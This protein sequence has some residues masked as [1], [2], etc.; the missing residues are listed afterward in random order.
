MNAVRVPPAC[1]VGYGVPRAGVPAPSSFDRWVR[2]A[3]AHSA[4]R[5]AIPGAY[6]CAIRLV[7]AREG[8]QLNHFWRG[9]DHATN[10]LSFPSQVPG[11]STPAQFW[12]GD[13]VLCAPVIARESRAQSRPPRDHYA[14]L[15]VH[16]VLHLL[17]FDHERAADA[18][19]MEALERDILASLEIPD[20]YA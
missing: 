9:Q 18:R 4:R 7:G 11:L 5:G 2:A 12:L 16:G 17:G 3:L 20:P 8:R 19:A 1:T 14:H 15:T 13:I 6:A 10:V